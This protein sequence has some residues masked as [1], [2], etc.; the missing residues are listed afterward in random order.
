MEINLLRL[1]SL[2]RVKLFGRHFLD[3]LESDVE[4][5]K[6]VDNIV[7]ALEV[8]GRRQHDGA[9]TVNYVRLR[10]MAQKLA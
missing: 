9:F 1:I 6:V 8:V 10:F 7:E 3:E 5:K 4:R 2:Y